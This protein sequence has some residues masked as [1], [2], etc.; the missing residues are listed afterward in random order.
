MEADGVPEKEI[1]IVSGANHQAYSKSEI[2]DDPENVHPPSPSLKF[3]NYLH[4][5]TDLLKGGVNGK[6]HFT[7]DIPALSRRAA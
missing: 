6:A 1:K 7:Y 4:N 5:I 3:I 2:R